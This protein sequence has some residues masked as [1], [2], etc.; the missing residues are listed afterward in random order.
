EGVGGAD[1]EVEA[2]TDQDKRH[3][4]RHDPDGR[5]LLA[6]V[7]QVLLGQEPV[8]LRPDDDDQERDRDEDPVVAQH[9]ARDSTAVPQDGL[10]DELLAGGDRHVGNMLLRIGSSVSSSPRNSPATVPL[11]STTTRSTSATSSSVS[12]ETM[13]RAIP[14]SASCRSRLR[15]S[16]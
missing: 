14:C 1:G 15:I 5:P 10:T 13:I 12:S 3:A 4:G 6:D 11:L 9:N 8:V 7:E 2:A 16:A